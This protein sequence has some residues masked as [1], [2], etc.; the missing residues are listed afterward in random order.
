MIVKYW[1]PGDPVDVPARGLA[2]AVGVFDGVHLG[3]QALLKRVR[4]RAAAEGLQAACL[5][6]PVNPKRI[7]SPATFPGNIVS[8]SEK[9][10]LLEGCGLDLCLLA[11]FDSAFAALEGEDFL[12][13]LRDRLGLRTLILGENSRLGR[14]GAMHAQQAMAAALSLGLEAVIVPSHRVGR[15]VASSSAIRDAIE[16]GRMDAAN[17]LLGRRHVLYSSEFENRREG[18]W[19]ILSGSTQE[20]LMPG[21]GTY[22]VGLVSTDGIEE[23]SRLEVRADGGLKWMRFHSQ[24]LPHAIVFI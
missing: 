11:N 6:F 5:S 4:E 22:E 21:P 23:R 18:S 3:H 17:A 2:I 7:L 19:L 16:A 1:G 8:L 9:L 14:G 20:I 12:A 10:R 15:W 13:L 24:P